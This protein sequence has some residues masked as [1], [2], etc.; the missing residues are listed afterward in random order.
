MTVSIE[1]TPSP[2]GS[3]P[4]P[5]HHFSSD[6]DD[7]D[8]DESRHR[9]PPRWLVTAKAL[10]ARIQN[11]RLARLLLQLQNLIYYFSMSNFDL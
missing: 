7:E 6:E 3:V 2:G 1:V 8:D 5:P 9:P 11:E 10:L 4:S